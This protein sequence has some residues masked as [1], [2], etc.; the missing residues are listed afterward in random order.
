ML[1]WDEVHHLFFFT[2]WFLLSF[3]YQCGFLKKQQPKKLFLLEIDLFDN[4]SILIIECVGK[5]DEMS[6]EFLPKKIFF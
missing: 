5:S 6:N 4:F 3:A 1:P 2:F